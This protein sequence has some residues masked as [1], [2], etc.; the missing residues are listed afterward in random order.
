MRFFG[1][2]GFQHRK[3]R[4]GGAASHFCPRQ[5]RLTLADIPPGRRMRVKGF[6]ACLPA[7]RQAHLQAYGLIVGHFIRVLQH[8]PITVIQI[9]HTELALEGGLARLVEVEEDTHDAVS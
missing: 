1:G 6:S 4:R 2:R 5:G 9:E 7:E 8:A 3:Q